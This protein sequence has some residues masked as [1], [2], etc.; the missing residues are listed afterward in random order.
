MKND[1]FYKKSKRSLK[2]SFASKLKLYSDCIAGGSK[3]RNGS[4][5]KNESIVN[6][7]M[8]TARQ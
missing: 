2:P 5:V 7:E 1:F 3:C 8:K 4:F 6:P